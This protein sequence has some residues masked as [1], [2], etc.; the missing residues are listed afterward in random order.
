V[1]TKPHDVKLMAS[2]IDWLRIKQAISLH[3]SYLL[4]VWDPLVGAHVKKIRNFSIILRCFQFIDDKHLLHTHYDAVKILNID[5]EVCILVTVR[6]GYS[7]ISSMGMYSSRFVVVQKGTA[8]LFE[9][10]HHG[11]CTLVATVGGVSSVVSCI[12]GHSSSVILF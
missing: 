11:N 2:C 3:E 9:V 8:V 1:A 12:D 4:S 6:P 5:A 7:C 10:D